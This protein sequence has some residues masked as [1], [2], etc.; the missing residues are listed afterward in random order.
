MRSAIP[1][2]RVIRTSVLFAVALMGA[3]NPFTLRAAKYP[4]REVTAK[5]GVS[6]LVS[7]NARCLVPTKEFAKIA[8]GQPYGCNWREN[9][10]V[11]LPSGE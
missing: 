8:V 9:G 10:A 4:L 11:V 5:E 3:C 7:R 1:A 2:K 6:V